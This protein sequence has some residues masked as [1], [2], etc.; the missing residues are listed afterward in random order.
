[1]PYAMIRQRYDVAFAIV[2]LI[3]AATCYVYVTLTITLPLR[4]YYYRY[5]TPMIRHD[6]HYD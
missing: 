1:M 5:I 3:I 4:E 6:S 2:T